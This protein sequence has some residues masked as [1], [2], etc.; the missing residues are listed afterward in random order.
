[1][2]MLKG[3]R[4]LWALG[5]AA[6]GGVLLAGVASAEVTTEQSGSIVVWPKVVWDG[7]R[8]T[9][10]T[11]SNTSNLMVHAHCFYINAVPLIPT[12]PPSALNPPQWNET[13][14][15][16]WLSRQQPT[17]WAASQGRQTSIF[18]PFG[19]DGAGL[20]P[21]LVPPVPQPFV[22]ELK[23]VQ[24]NDDGTPL[25][26]NALKGDAT[27][28]NSNGD[29]SAYNA[30]AFPGNPGRF[31]DIGN[32]L[33]LDLTDAN[34]GGAYSACP[35]TLVL[36]HFAEGAT[37]PVLDQLGTCDTVCYGGPTP[38]T[39]CTSNN[40]CGSGGKCFSCP[41]TTTLTL[42]PCSEDLENQVPGRVTVNFQVFNEFEQPLSGGTTVDCWMNTTLG[43]IPSSPFTFS[44]LGTLSASTRINPAAGFGGVIGVAEETRVNTTGVP[45]TAAFNIHVEG[46]RFDAATDGKGNPVA[47]VTDH[48][49]IPS[50]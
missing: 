38:G 31:G 12:L 47:G 19:S 30:I 1:M 14:F 40:D 25:P 21:G 15:D 5:T 35:D 50:E 26:G 22:G 10:I 48:I 33:T 18:D 43:A 13:D 37:D 23:C 24:V 27:L 34:P 11:V 9:I 28:R 6:I 29:V 45:T 2:R 49:V 8:D 44:Q 41:I 20:D 36:N 3:N 32:D 42:V 17:H 4:S 7:S 39:S 16:I 46:N